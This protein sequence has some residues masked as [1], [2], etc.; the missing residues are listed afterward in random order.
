MADDHIDYGECG[1]YAAHFATEAQRLVGLSQLVNVQALIDEV[2]SV[3]GSVAAELAKQTQKKAV[4]R[5]DGAN[6][7][8]AAEEGRQELA[9]F[10]KYLGTLDDDVVRDVNAFFPGGRQ[11]D[12]KKLKPADVQKKIASVLTGFDAPTNTA[13]PEGTK[14]K[15][16]LTQAEHSLK[17]AIGQK[18]SAVGTKIVHTAELAAARK[19]FLKTYIN[20]AKPLVRGLLAR[21]GREDEFSLYFRDETVQESKPRKKAPPAEAPAEG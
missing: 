12:L 21:L 4:V 7:A 2:M 14:W 20:V 15:N 9:R 8:D 13:L 3:A 10:F 19:A 6:V 1:E 18:T 16:K 17:I 5:G 11:G